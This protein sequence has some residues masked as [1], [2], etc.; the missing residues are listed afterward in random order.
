MANRW[1]TFVFAF[2]FV[3]VFVFVSAFETAQ[4]YYMLKKWWEA[5]L[6]GG[7]NT[8]Q[9]RKDPMRGAILIG[10]MRGNSNVFVAFISQYMA[11]T[12]F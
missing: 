6:G 5:E 11:N 10:G 9:T 2:V 7:S 3:S 8:E 1:N 12:K 4:L